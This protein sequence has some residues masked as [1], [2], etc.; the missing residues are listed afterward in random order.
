MKYMM[1]ITCTVPKAKISEEKKFAMSVTLIDSD[2]YLGRCVTTWISAES[3]SRLMGG[4]A[5][6]SL[7]VSIL[8]WSKWGHPS[9]A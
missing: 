9:S 3:H 6:S 8:G 2:P 4:C 1:M 5:E 7:G